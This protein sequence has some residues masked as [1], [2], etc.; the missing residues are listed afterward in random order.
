[1]TQQSKPRTKKAQLIQM[2]NRKA[3]ADVA[4]ISKRL[5]WLPH[6][7]RAALTGLRKAG[8]EI[9]TE[10]SGNGKSVVLPHHGQ[11]GGERRLMAGDQT[12]SA[13]WKELGQMDRAASAWP[14]RRRSETPR[15]TSCR[16]PT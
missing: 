11:T 1:M 4:A 2:L 16:W 6:T 9:S 10:K 7:T 12:I 5:G 8:Y 13:R 14:G 3:G 15:L